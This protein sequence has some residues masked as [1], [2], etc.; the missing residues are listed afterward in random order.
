MNAPAGSVGRWPIGS[1][2]AADE[3]FRAAFAAT[4]KLPARRDE[5]RR[6]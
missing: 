3:I 2:G 5:R 1:P 4:I 6:R